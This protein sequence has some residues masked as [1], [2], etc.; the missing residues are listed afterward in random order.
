MPSANR[1]PPSKSHSCRTCDFP[2]VT[3][4]VPEDDMASAS[5][6][7]SSAMLWI[8]NRVQSKGTE[9][10]SGH[11]EQGGKEGDQEEGCKESA[12]NG[13]MDVVVERERREVRVRSKGR[14][15]Y[16]RGRIGRWALEEGEMR[17]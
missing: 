5:A 14:K 15:E 9:N 12:A 13:I 10:R 17:R 7:P 8:C 6:S 2:P 11:A 16:D 4:N 1:L 3:M